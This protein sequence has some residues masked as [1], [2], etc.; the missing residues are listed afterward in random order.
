MRID[1]LVWDSKSV[2]F[3]NWFDVTELDGPK[4]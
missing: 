1:T 4:C 2:R 3:L